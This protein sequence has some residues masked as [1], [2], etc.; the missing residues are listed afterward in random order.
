MK[1]HG[2]M[3]FYKMATFCYLPGDKKKGDKWTR[4]QERGGDS[5][6]RRDMCLLEG[7]PES[8]ILWINIVLTLQIFTR[9]SNSSVRMLCGYSWPIVSKKLHIRTLRDYNYCQNF[10]YA[11][12][13]YHNCILTL[14]FSCEKL[15]VKRL[16][17]L[18]SPLVVPLITVHWI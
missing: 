2:G 16:L 5:W 14:S 4:G 3:I 9:I 12:K 13:C 10:T 6:G 1:T 18:H 17:N 7:F 8:S 11:S 15:V